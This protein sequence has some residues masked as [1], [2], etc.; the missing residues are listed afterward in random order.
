MAA[1]TEQIAQTHDELRRR[2]KRPILY[3]GSV[4]LDNIRSIA[5]LENVD[6]VL[7]GS[8]SQEVE[9][10]HGLMAAVAPGQIDMD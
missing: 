7:V 3:G 8:A 5:A 10:F 9:S 6:G 2:I 1:E 4:K